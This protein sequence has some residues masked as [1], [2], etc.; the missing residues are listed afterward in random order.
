M[1]YEEQQIHF[2]T[3]MMRLGYLLKLGLCIYMMLQNQ[4][5]LTITLWMSLALL[6]PMTLTQSDLVPG[7]LYRMLRPYK[8][9]LS[10]A[11]VCLGVY[12]MNFENSPIPVEW[13]LYCVF[14]IYP[15]P[16][17]GA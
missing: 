15:S 9:G 11:L 10:A 1:N 12:Q 2:N 4:D 3:D 14:L 16:P 7:S 5:D 13:A 6:F 17:K 8:L